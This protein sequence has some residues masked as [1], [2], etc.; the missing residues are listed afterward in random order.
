MNT[1]RAKMSD[2]INRLKIKTG[3]TSLK[4]QYLEMQSW[5]FPRPGGGTAPS[6]SNEMD[7]IDALQ[8]DLVPSNP[9]EERDSKISSLQESLTLSAASNKEKEL[10]IAELEKKLDDA[11]LKPNVA[12][13]KK[14]RRDLSIAQKKV[15]K[16]YSGSAGKL[17]KAVKE[18]DIPL[19]EEFD[20]TCALLASSFYDTPLTEE[21][22]NKMN[23]K[24]APTEATRDVFKPFREE[25][26]SFDSVK[27]ERF[28]RM[29]NKV[30]E[31]LKVSVESRRLSLSLSP[32][33]KRGKD[34]EV[35]E[36]GK[37]KM[38]NSRLSPK[39]DH[40]SSSLPLAKAKK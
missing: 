6:N 4:T 32:N 31:S 7:K 21:D 16:V 24:F 13:V 14:L 38:Q 22:I 30:V 19:D 3:Y 36:H 5:H 8:T 26:N 33:R 17:L 39:T 10:A 28:S 18:V 11:L 35:E 2:Y 15:D 40:R 37:Q 29:R 23:T 1:P 9:I 34:R 20:S 12:E 27:V 25:A